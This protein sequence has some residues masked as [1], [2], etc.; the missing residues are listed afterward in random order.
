[1]KDS[2]RKRI[3]FLFILV[4]LMIIN[5]PFVSQW[6]NKGSESR[7]INNY[8]TIVQNMSE[9]E[10]A[11]I[12]SMAKDYNQ[13]LA[14]S[15]TGITDAFSTASKSDE[16]YNGILNPGG[17]G[18][19]GYISIPKIDV[20]IPIYHGTSSSV[21]ESGAGHLY[22]SSLPVGGESTHAILSSHSGLPSKELFTNLDQLEIG[23][24][25]Y[26]KV[27]GE[28]LVYC[29][30]SIKTVLPTETESLVI[31]QG[32][33]LVTLVTCTPYGVNSHR[34]LV[35]GYRVYPVEE[36]DAEITS[37]HI[38]EG[39]SGVLKM[40]FIIS[41]IVLILAGKILLFPCR[42]RERRKQ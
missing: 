4:G 15:Q 39:I 2:T 31:K 13:R 35:T 27:M 33:D 36:E 28:K 7:V 17:D 37:E 6:V 9:D 22:G 20:N 32:E 21:L 34:L 40:I 10:K 14:Q 23:D 3:L 26:I 30:N 24:G 1:M 19:M 8:E 5:Y 42:K 12:I 41:I 29:I 38:E 18:I 25:F 11:G 16:E